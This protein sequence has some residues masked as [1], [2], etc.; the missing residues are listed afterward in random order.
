MNYNRCIFCGRLTDAPKSF[1][2]QSG[3]SGA[4][5]TLA[6]NSGYGEHQETLFIR[7]SVFG[8]PAE[9]LCQYVG[10]GGEVLVDGR[11]SQSDY[12]D[13]NGEKRRTMRLM[14][15]SVQFGAKTQQGVAQAQQYGQPKY[16]QGGGYASPQMAQYAPQYGYQQPMPQQQYAPPQFQP[17]PQEQAQQYIPRHPVDDSDVPMPQQ[18]SKPS[19]LPDDGT[20][21]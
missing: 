2:T 14:V 13:K 6:V 3:K 19:S 16:Q 11:L 12:T 18:P 21:F 8:K 9:S 5:F 17:M 20:P 7:C 15:E 4:E 10:K 1:A